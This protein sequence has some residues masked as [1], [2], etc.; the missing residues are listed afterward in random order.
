MMNKKNKLSAISLALVSQFTFMDNAY[1]LDGITDNDSLEVKTRTIFFDREYD[2]TPDKD[3]NTL[4]Q[5]LELNYQSGTIAGWFN[6]GLSAYGVANI[7]STGTDNAPGIMPDDPN[8]KN[9]VESA[10]GKIGQAYIEVLPTDGLSL[11][12]GYQKTKQMFFSTSTSRAIPSSFRGLTGSYQPLDS[13]KVY[14]YA[15]DQWSGRNSDEWTD[16]AADTDG[17]QIELIWGVG[18]Q[19]K[20]GKFNADVE[21][22]V[23]EDYLA[24]FGLRAS[25]N[26]TIGKGKLKLSGGYFTSSDN[27]ALFTESGDKNIDG[28]ESN[29]GSVWFLDAD[30]KIHAFSVGV[31]FSQT[32]E[33]WIEDNYKGDHGSNPLPTRA[34]IGPDFTNTNESV[35]LVRAGVDFGKLNYLFDGLT[36]KVTYAKGTDIENAADAS[37]GVA[38]E[39]F[40]AID[41]RYKVPMAKGLSLRYLYADYQSTEIGSVQG[42]KG[43][44]VDHRIYMDY[45]FKF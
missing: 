44:N 16:F 18:A 4:A 42:V 20:Q 13:V 11:K 8:D 17:P 23:S 33:I 2:E 28:I 45:S 10:F 6:I 15:F 14:G 29:D 40:F 32:G 27:G 36:T 39:K 31:A 43:D 35:W 24:K 34:P 5:A 19:F 38:E 21:Y 12:L 25:Y 37:L 7:N 30:Y 9:N 1:A 41:T 3:S 26:D 22:M